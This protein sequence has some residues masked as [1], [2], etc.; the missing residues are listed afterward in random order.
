[1]NYEQFIQTTNNKTQKIFL[2]NMT[3]ETH[4][5]FSQLCEKGIEKYSKEQKNITIIV[6][7]KWYASGVLCQDCG[8]IPQCKNCSVSI[9][10]HQ[11]IHKEMFGLCHICKNH[12]DKPKICEHCWSKNIRNYGLGIQQVADYIKERYNTEAIIID[13]EKANSHNKIKKIQESI[14]ENQSNIIL[15]TSLLSTPIKKIHSDLVIFLNADIGL[16]IPDYSAATKNFLLLYET[17]QNYNNSTIIIQSFQPNHYSI[18]SACKKDKKNFI[19]QDAQYRKTYLYPPYTDICVLVY[20]HEIEERLYANVDKLHKELLYYKEKY[21]Q[22]QIDIYTTPPLIYK[23]FGKYRY[24]IILKGKELKNFVDIIYSKCKITQR[25]FKV[26]RQ[27][28]S[29]I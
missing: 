25:W 4:P 15:G 26:D 7:K 11:D 12:Y 29:V 22:T 28:D 6:N 21:H 10:Y 23:K 17:I 3:K 1:M 5:Y 9:S 16:N 14:K 20:K 13:T 18:R 19:E 27:A 2:V 8:H 24:N